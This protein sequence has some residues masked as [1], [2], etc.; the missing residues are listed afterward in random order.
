VEFVQV[1]RQI[2]KYHLKYLKPVLFLALLIPRY[3]AK[4]ILPKKCA[5][6]SKRLRNTDVDEQ[7]R[8]L[9]VG[10]MSTWSQSYQTFFFG[11]QRFFPV[12]VVKLECL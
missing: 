10:E 6:N 3:A 1:C 4:F 12:F 11:K 2:L 7:S 5:A 9:D 8:F